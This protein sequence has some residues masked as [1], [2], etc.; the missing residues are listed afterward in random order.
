M[1]DADKFP[2][3]L[4]N[5]VTRVELLGGFRLRIRF[6]DGATA[7]HDFTAF[8]N[9]PG[10]MREPL[11]DPAYFAR[12]YLDN[13]ALTWPNGYDMCPD[14]LRMTLE[15]AGELRTSASST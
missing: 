4:L 13:G 6:Q 10:Q 15:D 7:E 14:W 9:A 11:R 5:E 1:T 8:A 3:S 2:R 12:V